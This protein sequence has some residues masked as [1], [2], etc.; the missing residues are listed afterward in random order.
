MSSRCLPLA[1]K[2]SRRK[3]NSRRSKSRRQQQRD[4]RRQLVFE[5]L[6]CRT[7][8]DAT[9]HNV[10]AGLVDVVQ[11][12]TGNTTASVTVTAPYP[13]ND[14]RIRS[15]FN[16][17]DFN[18]QIGPSA[19]DDLAGGIIMASITENGRDNGEG[20]GTLYGAAAIDYERTGANAVAYW[21]ITQD[22]TANRTEYN[23]D[24]AAAYFPYGDG[25]YGGLAR[26]A[27]AA[28]GGANNLFTGHQALSW[29]PTS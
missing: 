23:F 3:V 21:L 20:S 17:G 4:Q 9:L 15:G 13:F 25:W 11:N 29:A 10:A 1:S 12:D 14:F 18:V 24:L 22:T 26:N 2:K 19:T 8:L 28:N 27:T 16:R 7:L 6:E 5:S